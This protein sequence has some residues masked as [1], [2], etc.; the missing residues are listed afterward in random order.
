MKKYRIKTFTLME[1]LAVI[2]IVS[3]LF[4]V[5]LPGFKKMV[6][7]NAVERAAADLKLGLEKAQAEAISSRRYVALILGN[8]NVSGLEPRYQLGGYRIA[9]VDRELN[10][11][12]ATSYVFAGWVDGDAWKTANP[13]ARLVK[14]IAS[15]K[16]LTEDVFFNKASMNGKDI[17]TIWNDSNKKITW[18]SS[19]SG[20]LSI[21]GTQFNDLMDVEKVEKYTDPSGTEKMNKSAI[22]FSPYGGICGGKNMQF[23][24]AECVE[25]G[26]DLYF[27]TRANNGPINY[28]VLQVNFLTGRISYAE[29][30]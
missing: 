8:N 3:V 15:D 22:I 26:T 7:G 20:S 11:S 30:E 24:I 21:T 6:K 17:G 19:A 29:L 13:E 4:T 9:Y 10:A 18:K 14:I 23:V 25:D 2:A 28:F 1:L 27:P 12:N 16:D 5:M